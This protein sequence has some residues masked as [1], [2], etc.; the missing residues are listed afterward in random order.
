MH[1]TVVDEQTAD[2]LCRMNNYNFGATVV[3]CDRY[4]NIC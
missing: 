3:K 1:I 2:C 4:K